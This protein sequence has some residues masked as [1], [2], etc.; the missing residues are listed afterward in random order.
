MTVR[1]LVI[2]PQPFFSPRGT[3]LSVYYRTLVLSELGVH[4]DLVTYGEGRDVTMP[5]LEIIRIPRF[6]WL[7]NVK[8]GPSYL[9]LFLDFFLALRVF[10]L[11]LSRRYDFLHAHEEAIFICRFLKP[12]FGFKLV[13]DMHSNLA[14]Q[15]TN[16]RFTRSRLLKSVFRRLQESCIRISDV[17][18]TICPDLA[19]YV[20]T[21]KR[22]SR[23]HIL[24]ENSIFDPVHLAEQASAKSAS[25]KPLQPAAF[26][27]PTDGRM[28]L[29]A[30]TLEPYQGI[31]LLLTAFRETIRSCPDAFL[32]VVGGTDRQ[33]QDYT[34]MTQTLGIAKQVML[35]GNLPHAQVSR[36]LERAAVLVSPRIE[37][38][39]T[40]LKVYQQLAS[41]I[42][43]VA[44][45]IESH[46]QI[47]DKTVAF[48]ALPDPGCFA[49]AIVCALTRQ[50]D[51]A[52]RA[53]RAQQL[54]MAKYSRPS[55]TQKVRQVLEMVV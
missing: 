25:E 30:G 21:V 46:T 45:D 48:L 19:N 53:R 26:N 14:Q 4:V 37:G 36:H 41:G 38:T 51:A 35:L 27:L 2:A 24:I 16:T 12:V 10:V 32:L 55:Y 7:G 5:H 6:R 1:A 9:K 40:P 13:Y 3:P 39:N 34:N 43:L 52:N 15:L 33:V 29:Y 50:E 22:E 17:V 42:P 54:Y 8:V 18:I 44:T 31:E 47:L 28:V 23:N 20:T 11:L 49:H